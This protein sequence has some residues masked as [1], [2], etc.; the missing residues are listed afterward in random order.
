MVID[1]EGVVAAIRF[2]ISEKRYA[3][4]MKITFIPQ[5]SD[6]RFDPL[7]EGNIYRIV[8]EALNNAERHSEAGTVSI[9]LRSEEKSIGLSITD[10]GVGFD[11]ATISSERFGIRGM[12]ERARIFGG[13]LQVDSTPGKGTTIKASFPLNP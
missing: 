3:E 4:F 5:V 9:N 11:P 13:D 12:R 10:D 1:D 6:Q 7:L 8:Q 2:L